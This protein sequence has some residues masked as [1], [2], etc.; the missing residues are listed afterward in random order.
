MLEKIY[1]RLH[2]MASGP[3]EQGEYSSGYWQRR[4]REHAVEMCRHH[5]GR[6]LDVG[7]GEGLFLG[8][9][10]T[11]RPDMEAWGVDE[12][13]VILSRAEKRTAR[14]RTGVRLLRADATA[15]PFGDASFDVVVCINVFFNMESIGK[16]R[17][18][19]KEMARVC[20]KGGRLIFDFRNSL[21][22]LLAVKYRLAAYYD[23]TVRSLPLNTYD[24][25]NI[26]EI[27]GEMNLDITREHGLFF[28]VRRFAPVIVMETVKK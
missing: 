14:M 8:R 20:R 4:I 10:V 12:W 25:G 27:L 11:A 7:C 26:K 16:V 15:L 18:A 6:L 19:L 9:M 1:Y 24:P 13:E 21:N 22:P 3:G 17:S 2:R 23:P 28:A 5:R